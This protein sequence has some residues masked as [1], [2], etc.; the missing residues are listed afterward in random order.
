MYNNPRFDFS[1]CRD[2]SSG[3][4]R[5]M[6]E[7]ESPKFPADRSNRREFPDTKEEFDEEE[8]TKDD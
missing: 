8:K 6:S 2:Q 1:L 3:K 5:P 4:F 7:V